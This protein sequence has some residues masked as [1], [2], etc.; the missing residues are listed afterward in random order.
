MSLKFKDTYCPT[1]SSKP[2]CSSTSS[3][4]RRNTRTTTSTQKRNTPN[5]KTTKSKYMYISIL[6]VWELSDMTPCS[7]VNF[8]GWTISTICQLG[9]PL[10][11]KQDSVGALLLTEFSSHKGMGAKGHNHHH[12]TQMKCMSAEIG[13]KYNKAFCS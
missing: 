9:H 1:S 7:T 10:K 5:T 4:G 6:T 3:S 11:P 13:I 2:S 8:T 12:T